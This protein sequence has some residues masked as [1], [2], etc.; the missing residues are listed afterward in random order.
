MAKRVRHGPPVGRHVP[1]AVNSDSDR[2][3]SDESSDQSYS[4][5]SEDETEKGRHS[6]AHLPFDM[7]EFDPVVGI[8]TYRKGYSDGSERTLGKLIYLDWSKHPPRWRHLRNGSVHKFRRLEQVCTD[9]RFTQLKLTRKRRL[10]ESLE[11]E[12]Y[13]CAIREMHDIVDAAST[14]LRNVTAEIER[15]RKRG[16]YEE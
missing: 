15:G 8:H 7:G 16:K 13:H 9:S 5:S 4:V 14:D 11:K 12:I 2:D 1:I 3:D 10:A 6:L